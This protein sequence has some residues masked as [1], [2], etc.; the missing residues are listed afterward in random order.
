M[1]NLS[2][3][4]MRKKQPYRKRPFKIPFNIKDVPITAILGCISSILM[5]IFAG[6]NHIVG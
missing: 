4:I 2:V 3:I 5:I 1:V 6:K